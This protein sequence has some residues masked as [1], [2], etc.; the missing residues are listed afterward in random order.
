MKLLS[1]PDLDHDH[2]KARLDSI[3]SY[4]SISEDDH[5][6]TIIETLHDFFRDN[7]DADNIE[8]CNVQ[9]SLASA[10]FWYELIDIGDD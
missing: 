4:R 3:L 1:F 6:M 5:I 7:Y 2:I 9:I 10:L 8:A